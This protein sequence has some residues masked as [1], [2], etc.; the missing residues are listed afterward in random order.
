MTTNPMSWEGV[1]NPRVA[2][3]QS[4]QDCL[5]PMGA[6]RVPAVRPRAGGGGNDPMLCAK[7]QPTSAAPAPP[8]LLSPRR[9]H[10]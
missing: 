10:V 8:L 2:E 9:H 1:I 7:P 6:W 4:A 5:L 3:S